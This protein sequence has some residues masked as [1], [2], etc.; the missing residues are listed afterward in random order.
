MFPHLITIGS[1][2][3]PSYGAL[4][5]LAFLVALW[6]ASRFAKERGMS[7]ERVVNLGVYCALAGMA[8]AKLLMIALDPELRSHPAEIF[9]LG[10]LQ[11][12]GIFFGGFFAALVFAWVYMR[13]QGVPGVAAS[14]VFGPRLP[15]G[16]GLWR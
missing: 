8:G 14:D 11:S 9:S 7:S 16:P 2:S 3:L 6:M 5:A 15:P 4:V 1:F 13:L 10:V 12:T